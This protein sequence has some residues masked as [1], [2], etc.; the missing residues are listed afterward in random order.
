MRRSM[1]LPGQSKVGHTRDFED[2]IVE[3]KFTERAR[4]NSTLTRTEAHM[5]NLTGDTCF[6]TRASE[7]AAGPFSYSFSHSFCMCLLSTYLTCA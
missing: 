3:I 6:F 5:Q 4:K 2:K 1:N 7:T